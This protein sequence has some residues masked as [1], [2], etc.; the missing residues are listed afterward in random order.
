MNNSEVFASDILNRK[1]LRFTSRILRVNPRGLIL[2]ARVNQFSLDNESKA[3]MHRKSIAL[4]LALACD[5]L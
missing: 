5:Q 1:N 3:S 4:V 2:R